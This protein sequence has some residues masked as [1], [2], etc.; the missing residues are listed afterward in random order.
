MILVY[1][2]RWSYG[3]FQ[4][5]NNIFYK[6][7][8]NLTT[9]TWQ[10]D[11]WCPT[12]IILFCTSDAC[13]F[14]VGCW[15]KNIDQWPFKATTYF[16]CWLFVVVEFAALSKETTSPHTLRP[17]NAS[18]PTATVTWKPSCV[19][20][21]CVSLKRWPP[22]AKAHCPSLLFN[23]SRLGTPNKGKKSGEHDPDGSRPTHTHRRGTAPGSGGASSIPMERE[24]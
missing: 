5:D 3:T 22:K 2:G 7:K 4:D 13:M 10:D 11:I 20:L 6:M 18:S 8:N 17:S 23:G 19:W 12:I 9:G 21:L 24:G 16:N 15:M 1:L 14:L